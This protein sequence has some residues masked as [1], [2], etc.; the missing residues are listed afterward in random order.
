VEINIERIK[1]L[2][3]G[4]RETTLRENLAP[5]HEQKYRIIVHQVLDVL[6]CLPGHVTEEVI[7][8]G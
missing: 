5:F 7:V 2:N 8:K 6:L 1:N 3:G 4:T